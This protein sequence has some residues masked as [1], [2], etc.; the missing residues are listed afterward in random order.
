MADAVE[1][2]EASKAQIIAIRQYLDHLDMAKLVRPNA[3]CWA[4]KYIRKA[5]TKRVIEAR[6]TLYAEIENL[7]DA[8]G[9]TGDANEFCDE[10]DPAADEAEL[11]LARE[12]LTRRDIPEALI[13]VSRA[14][15]E[16]LR[17]LPELVVEFYGLER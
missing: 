13:H 6:D 17:F 11:D 7:A 3:T 5:H 10:Y 15:P 14:A 4:I 12:C 2:L 8:L 9:L 1:T 16:H